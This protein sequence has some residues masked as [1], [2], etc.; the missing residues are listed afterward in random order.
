MAQG[1]NQTE[2]FD[3]KCF[4]SG[5]G[6]KCDLFGSSKSI[7]QP[8]E[9]FFFILQLFGRDRLGRL[10]KVECDPLRVCALIY[11]TS[12]RSTNEAGNRIGIYIANSREALEAPH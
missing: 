5:K 10:I 12:N 8:A 2:I 6:N 9:V 1:R 11:E 4:R 3:H 7:S